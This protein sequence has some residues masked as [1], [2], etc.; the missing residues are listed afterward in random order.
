VQEYADDLLALN[1]CVTFYGP[2]EELAKPAVQRQIY[3]EPV[4]VGTIRGET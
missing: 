3:G 4:C 1:K 2:S